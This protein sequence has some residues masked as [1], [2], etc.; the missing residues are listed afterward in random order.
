MR[1]LTL[2]VLLLATSSAFAGSKF[3]RLDKFY[4]GGSI[5]SIDA[6][7]DVDEDRGFFSTELIVGYKY[8]GFLGAEIRLGAG[9]E[10]D[11][12][13]GG[14]GSFTSASFFWRPETSNSIAKIYGLIGFATVSVP[15]TDL[16]ESGTQTGG[17]LGGGFGFT[18][19]EA[20]NLN[21]EYR[22]FINASDFEAK[23]FSVN[24]DYR[25]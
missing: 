5:N 20:W 17:A 15:E 14:S 22:Y 4:V 11:N 16:E 10:E 12:G 8:N 2:A 21:F 24:V 13:S 7:T 6:K 1:F 23:G 3:D 9:S 18:F 25:F 19:N